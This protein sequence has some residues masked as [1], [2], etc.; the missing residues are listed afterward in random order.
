MNAGII[1][2]ITADSESLPHSFAIL[3]LPELTVTLLEL[4]WIIFMD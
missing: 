4:N 1:Q 3:P 2:G